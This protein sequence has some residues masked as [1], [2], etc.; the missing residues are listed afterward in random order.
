MLAATTPRAEDPLLKALSQAK[1]T[2]ADG[3]QQVS[4]SPEIAISA[5]FELE[6]GKLSLSVYTAEKGLGVA[7]EKNVLKEYAGDPTADSWK[8]EVE[9][10]KDVEHVARSAEQLTLMA[11]SPASLADIARKAA[12]DQPGTVY[13]ITPILRDRKA[14]FVVLVADKDKSVELEYDLM[15][16]ESAKAKP[17]GYK[18]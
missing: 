14:M 11:L 8:P 12:K 18:K 7:A 16:G 15:T 2:L 13:S 1:H 9:A 10:F 3:L 5:K 17:A 4:K 6:D